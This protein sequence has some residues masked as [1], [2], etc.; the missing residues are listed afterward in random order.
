ML[1][2]TLIVVICL[3]NQGGCSQAS[4]AYYKSSPQLQQMTK[5]SEKF[6]KQNIPE[7]IMDYIFPVAIFG[8]GK[9]GTVKLSN[10]WAIELDQSNGGRLFFRWNY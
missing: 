3:N 4:E 8:I 10:H 6:A 5:N 7:P 9:R 1:L 2:E